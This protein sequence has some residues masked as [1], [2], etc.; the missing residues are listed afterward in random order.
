MLVHLP[1][2]MMKSTQIM[3][4]VRTDATNAGNPFGPCSVR[5]VYKHADYTII[6]YESVQC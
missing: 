3:I 2:G 6:P 5:F 1:M 4:G